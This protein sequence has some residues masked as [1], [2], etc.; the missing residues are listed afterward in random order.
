MLEVA[1]ESG[2]AVLGAALDAEMSLLDSAISQAGKSLEDTKAYKEYE[3]L[4]LSEITQKAKA[5][6]AVAQCHLGVRYSLGEGVPK[7]AR[8]AFDWQ[9]KSA[10]QG[11]TTCQF[12]VAYRYQFDESDGWGGVQ[13]DLGMAAHWYRKAAENGH[14]FAQAQLAY[15]YSKGKGVPQNFQQAVYWYRKSAE[16]GTPEGQEGL[17]SRYAN[18]EGVTQDL[19]LAYALYDLAAQFKA[20]NDRDRTLVKIA[21]R[22]RDV[23]AEYMSPEQIR[24]GKEI[25]RGWRLGKPLPTASKTGPGQTK[26]GR[27]LS[28]EEATQKL[29]EEG[30]L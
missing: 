28:D 30:I 13:Q 25:L 10:E 23:C 19:A 29:K 24:E 14:M 9:R 6:D 3:T 18:G 17:A 15:L 2:I 1:L 4:S 7:D 11:F 12:F 27:K 22:N 16:Q 5:G 8:Q 20:K 21:A 26:E